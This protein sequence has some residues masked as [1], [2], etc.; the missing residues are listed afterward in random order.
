MYLWSTEGGVDIRYFFNW[1][2]PI[3]QSSSAPFLVSVSQ[4]GVQS[5]V[6]HVHIFLVLSLCVQTKVKLACM[7]FQAPPGMT[8]DASRTLCHLAFPCLRYK[9]YLWSPSLTRPSWSLPRL[10]Y[11]PRKL[12]GLFDPFYSPQTHTGTQ[13]FVLQDPAPGHHLICTSQS[14]PLLL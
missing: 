6:Q 9:L 2:S 1:H 5:S 12:V 7:A 11:L 3:H 14:L 8:L 13:L 10:L 4:G